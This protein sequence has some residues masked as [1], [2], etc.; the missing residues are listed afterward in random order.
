MSLQSD[1]FA[2]PRPDRFP[3]IRTTTNQA[4][5][6]RHYNRTIDEETP[7]MWKHARH[8]MLR[9]CAAGSSHSYSSLSARKLCPFKKFS[10]EPCALLSGRG[11]EP[12]ADMVIK[13][14]AAKY[15]AAMM[16]LACGTAPM[17]RS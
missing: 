2:K 6:H 12:L 15:V 14:W 13:S 4:H 7:H 3:E 16:G 1:T 11:C 8:N 9:R 5:G 10:T 17:N